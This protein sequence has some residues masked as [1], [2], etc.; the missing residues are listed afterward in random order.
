M[1]EPGDKSSLVFSDVYNV[2][3]L[4][5]ILVFPAAVLWIYCYKMKYNRPQLKLIKQLEDP[6]F[7]ATLERTNPGYLKHL[8]STVYTEE[9]H[10]EFISRFGV[11]TEELDM[12]K[13]QENWIRALVFLRI[14]RQLLLIAIV[15]FVRHLPWLTLILFNF[16]QLSMVMFMYS[17]TFYFYKRTQRL[18][19]FNE[20]SVLSMIYIFIG[21]SDF[22]EGT[23]ARIWTG[24]QLIRLATLCFV[25]NMLHTAIFSC[26][27][28]VYMRGLRMYRHFKE[29]HSRKERRRKQL[30]KQYELR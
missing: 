10:D 26:S 6:N 24:K 8:I 5:V 21:L 2:T 29:R 1:F 30:K 19:M 15:V 18:E 22:V 4:V 3:A 20:L 16:V 28:P 23:E 13:S 17:H 11:L 14:L 7:C 9:K 12:R 27:I 25:V